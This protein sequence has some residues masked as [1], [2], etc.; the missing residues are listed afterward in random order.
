MES[1]FVKGLKAKAK[2]KYDANN[3][4]GLAEVKS[5]FDTYRA[6]V[7]Y[8]NVILSLMFLVLGSIGFVFMGYLTQIWI[9][10]GHFYF[11][12]MFGLTII[13]IAIGIILWGVRAVASYAVW[14]RMIKKEYEPEQIFSFFTLEGMS[15]IAY[16]IMSPLFLLFGIISA[17]FA[18][19]C[20]GAAIVLK[21][22]MLWFSYDIF[23]DQ[24]SK[25]DK[26]LMIV[27]SLGA[28]VLCGIFIKVFVV[29]G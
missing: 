27:S 18:T 1:M 24:C 10:N 17:Y 19:L 6:L 26:T 11:S 3:G 20:I 13:G 7:G 22:G 4:T 14:K 12:Q 28:V 8:N 5:L 9:R 16:L 29:G 15:D 2:T 25:A 23:V 21:Y